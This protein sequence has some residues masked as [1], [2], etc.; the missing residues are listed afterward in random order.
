MERPDPLANQARLVQALL[1]PA[2]YPHPV[3]RVE[4]IETHISTVLLAGEY[5]YKIKKPLDLGFLDFT[6]LEDRAHY[7]AEEIRLNARLAPGIYLRAVPIAGTAESPQLDG[8]GTPI[9][10]AVLMRRFPQESQLDR[11]FDAGE[12]PLA[13]CDRLAVR[14]AEFHERAARAEPGAAYGSPEVVVAPMRENFAQLVPLIADADT[15]DR[16]DRLADW[17]ET[18]YTDL[19]PVLTLRQAEGFVREC[20]GDM[21]LANIALWD[22][23][24]II[25]DG[26][27]FNPHLRWIDVMSELAFLTMDLDARGAGAHSYRVLN[28]YL[29]QTGDYAGLALL[30][31]YQ[32]YRCMVRTKV[33]AIRACQNGAAEA[34][35]TES[36]TQCLR[37]LDL[38]EHYAR[39]ARPRLVITHGF[40]GSGKTT[41]A[42]RLVDDFGFIRIR[43]DVERK[44]LAGLAAAARTRST[45][46]SGLYDARATEAT[47]ARLVELAEQVLGT[48]IPV[49]VD[50]TFLKLD[51][52]SRF[53]RLAERLA[54]PVHILDVQAGEATLRERIRRRHAEARD[55]SEADLEVLAHQ[56]RTAEPLTEAE[57]AISLTVDADARVPASALAPLAPNAIPPD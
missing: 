14:L 20:H 48:G 8:L 3:D 2:C 40:S 52:R 11:R 24:L 13:I 55:A 16:L 44:R 19:R 12:V 1:D 41:V 7:C 5:A 27:E 50:A 37:Y 38:A 28:G 47:Y 39:P 56:L 10:W 26:I 53:V 45:L 54:I 17:T 51:Q 29:E 31:F 25:F 33:G 15:R 9:E 46:G 30:R 23:E 35:R 57:R 42:Q 36:W 6:R 4:R 18:R 22:D 49:L 21:H 32:V 34:E 43:S